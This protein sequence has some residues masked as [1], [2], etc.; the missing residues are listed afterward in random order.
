MPSAE[1][2]VPFQEC[3]HVVAKPGLRLLTV[4]HLM[5][6]EGPDEDEPPGPAAAFM[7]VEPGL[8]L[9]DLP[10][11]HRLLLAFQGLDS[12]FRRAVLLFQVVLF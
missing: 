4:T 7:G 12:L 8:S 3:V 1:R 11:Q 6:H 5:L 9:P 10:G 2:P